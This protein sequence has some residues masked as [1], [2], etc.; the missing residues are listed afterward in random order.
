MLTEVGAAGLPWLE[1]FKHFSEGVLN[2]YY[3]W[4][5][6]NAQV[7]L[8]NIIGGLYGT[9]VSLETKISGHFCVQKDLKHQYPGGM[10][11][12]NPVPWCMDGVKVKDPLR[13][14][15]G[16]NVREGR[17][18]ICIN[19]AWGTICD[20]E[21]FGTQDAIV[22]C[23]QMGFSNRGTFWVCPNFTIYLL[24][25]WILFC[26]SWFLLDHNL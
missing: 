3:S 20:D 1:H 14:V 4:H 22:V 17:V 25:G 24:Y 21:L 2:F 8:S 13:L 26:A 11:V 18:E 9:L 19:N 7:I 23:T 5:G 12:L 15:G 6:S 10:S 16:A